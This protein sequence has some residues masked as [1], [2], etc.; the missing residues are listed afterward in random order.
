M[1]HLKDLLAKKKEEFSRNAQSCASTDFEEV[2]Q[3]AKGLE[4]H[5]IIA[6]LTNQ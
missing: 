6:E 3:K 1:K 2:E 5:K 4:L